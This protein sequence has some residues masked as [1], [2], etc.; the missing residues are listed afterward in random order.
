MQIWVICRCL[1][2]VIWLALTQPV[3]VQFLES[4]LSVR[5]LQQNLWGPFDGALAIWTVLLTLLWLF[6]YVPA[7]KYALDL[8]NGVELFEQFL[9]SLEEY[10]LG[11]FTEAELFEEVFESSA[12]KV[13]IWLLQWSRAVWRWDGKLNYHMMLKRNPFEVHPPFVSSDL[14]VLEKY[15]RRGKTKNPK[16]R[17][18]HKLSLEFTTKQF[19]VLGPSPGYNL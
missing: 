3:L 7:W 10:A 6:S 14:V 11:V 1:K 2:L 16:S 17:L 9:A 8:F 5:L 18:A 13:W 4:L 12:L 15:K 19:V